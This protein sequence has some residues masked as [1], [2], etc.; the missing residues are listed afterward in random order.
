MDMR[1]HGNPVPELH[2]EATQHR[3]MGGAQRYPSL[4]GNKLMGIAAL[5]PSYELRARFYGNFNGGNFFD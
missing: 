3:R 5:H 4:H 2:K 1:S